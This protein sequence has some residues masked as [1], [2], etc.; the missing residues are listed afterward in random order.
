MHGGGWT[1][2]EQNRTELP[3]ALQL[4]KGGSEEWCGGGQ[5]VPECE[6]NNYLVLSFVSTLND[7]R[8]LYVCSYMHH[9]FASTPTR[10]Y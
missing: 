7:L 9:D 3:D 1:T 4:R 5:R 6:N 8:L 2:V 10:A